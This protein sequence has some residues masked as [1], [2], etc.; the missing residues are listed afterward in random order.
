MR[1]VVAVTLACG[2]LALTGCS[3]SKNSTNSDDTTDPIVVF[4]TPLQGGS[5]GSGA[6]L[7]QV[8]ATDN[9]GVTKVEFFDG[10]TKIGEDAT[11]GA[12]NKYDVSWTA[13]SGSHTLKAV[14]HD[15]AANTG[16]SSIAVSVTGG[17]TLH[18]SDIH[19]SETWYPSGNPH[20]ITG[21]IS[22]DD[23]VNSPILTIMPGCVV[24]FTGV[25]E[26]YCGYYNSGAIHAEGKADSLITFTTTSN[27]KTPGS[28]KSVT[29]YDKSTST[30]MF[31]YCVFE[32][33]G[34]SSSQASL[35]VNGVGV[36]VTNCVVRNSLSSGM[37]FTGE[38]G[39]PT[40][41]SNNAVNNCGGHAIEIPADYVRLMTAGNSFSGNTN[42]DILVTTTRVATTGTWRNHGVPYL[43]LN[44]LDVDDATNSPILTIAPGCTIKLG[45]NVEFYC[46]YYSHGTIIAE[47][48]AD[49]IITFTTNTN[50][51]S[52]GSWRAV[53]VYSGSSTAS[54]FNYCRFE[55]GGSS[56]S[57]AALM[58]DDVVAKVTNCTITQSG[59]SGIRLRGTAR[60]SQF[61]GN[62]ISNCNGHA[63]VLQ[64][65]Y[66]RSL[67]AGNTYSG[68]TNNDIL[69]EA[70][71]LSTTCT[72]LNQG[73]PYVISGDVSVGDASNAP[74]L[75]IATQS[76]LKMHS[77]VEFYVGYYGAGGLIADSVTFTSSLPFPSPGSWR[78]LSFYNL[79]MDG[80]S[81]L[82][83]CTI[84]YA[85][86]MNGNVYI[87]DAI[88]VISGCTIRNSAEW[89]IYLGGSSHP[90]AA[91]LESL[92]SFSGNANGNVGP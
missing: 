82:T 16:E 90:D 81:R 83:N 71:N 4:V 15:A 72:W 20:R 19:E 67:G 5:V 61:T 56:S 54:S 62:I 87:D 89:G 45:S 27:P 34:S 30:T 48:K 46:G 76:T 14:A 53:E 22:V 77:N 73:A 42:N 51:P 21:D 13:T 79:A 55:Y 18:S 36:P 31:K 52:P 69:V 37:K 44:E 78:A 39:R 84:E 6:V 64:P 23:A 33:G 38:N 80:A 75:T 28:W 58:F 11:A 68:N 60:F 17:P 50:P 12:G 57:E 8:T 26:L 3:K 86:G 65:E 66:V 29:A 70:G 2:I 40:Q 25:Y 7:V 9:V 85:G 49:S 24:E 91:M 35:Y 92:N 59:G 32:Y 41:F 1:K 10:A 74:V 47:G 63:I 43:L 88:P